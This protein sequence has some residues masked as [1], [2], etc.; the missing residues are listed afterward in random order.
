MDEVQ[1]KPAEAGCCD[2]EV[3]T[4]FT[5]DGSNLTIAHRTPHLS[6]SIAVKHESILDFLAKPYL[7]GQGVFST[8][9]NQ[10][11]LLTYFSIGSQLSSVTQWANKLT[12]FNLIRGKAKIRLIIN[13]NPFQQGKLLLSLA[14][15][16]THID[17]IDSSFAGKHLS[18]L[19]AIRQLPCVEHDLR[20]STTIL[21]VPYVTPYHWYDIKRAVYDWGT[22]FL[23]VMSPLL[24][25]AGGETT[26]D[27]SLFLSFEEVELAAPMITQMGKVKSKKGPP[28]EK[29]EDVY[30]G[31]GNVSKVLKAV[32][33]ASDA[34]ASVPV[35]API[36]GPVAWVTA[37]ASKAAA[38]FGWSKPRSEQPPGIMSKMYNRYMSTYDGEDT[39]VPLGLSA[40][41]K[42]GVSNETTLYDVDEMSFDFLKQVS[43]WVEDASW[44][45]SDVSGTSI[46]GKWISP[47]NIYEAGSKTIGAHT[48][49]Y[50][51]GPPIFYLANG[52]QY[53]R[54]SIELTIKLIKTDYHS[55]RLLITFTPYN[56]T[57]VTVPTTATSVL[58]L[59]EIVDI[60]TTDEIKL[61]LPYLL[62]ENFLNTYGGP[63]GSSVNMGYLNITVLNELRNPE[64]ASGTVKLQMY[65]S[66]GADFEFAG[67][68][69][70]LYEP[71]S[72]Q[73]DT[74]TL[75]KRTDKAIGDQERV[76]DSVYYSYES[77]GEKFLSVKQLLS[78]YC[79]LWTTSAS[80]S[81]DNILLWPWAAGINY[82]AA[83][84]GNQGSPTVGADAYNYLQHMYL[85]YRGGI[86]IGIQTSSTGSTQSF[87]NISVCN[88]VDN[89]A[90]GGALITNGTNVCTPG[91]VSNNNLD[92]TQYLRGFMA[93]TVTD[94]GN[95][96]VA[97]SV[98][99]YGCGR[100]S[101]V[102]TQTTSA[103]VPQ[104]RSTPCNKLLIQSTGDCGTF[105]LYRSC[106]DDFYFSYFIGCPPVM[107]SYT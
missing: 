33:G 29:E 80:G 11:D 9:N 76:P 89:A 7:V 92:T 90:Y 59:R 15:C 25:G 46:Y 49:N 73:M 42:I 13:S 47:L 30:S 69:R 41:N 55:G 28:T 103:T 18:T 12:G 62:A 48:T 65:Y 71:F 106:N 68:K 58:A 95:G 75:T 99:Y 57:A 31:G 64:T 85:F 4:T 19:A 70:F 77:M 14:P 17:A 98:P 97:A 63:T 56:N 20:D 37:A 93:P 5:D 6:S 8:T 45:N 91:T 82:M 72:T 24:T 83:G 61:N 66:G 27:Y 60:R 105:A 34:L 36:A 52:F 74:S 40:T 107:Y 2:S 84:T 10:R 78:R 102:L 54:G 1:N 3:T 100:A 16:Y 94:S 32:S 26:V 44:A 39:S 104:D 50:R 51:C 88:I 81:N 35:L 43:T 86:R 23:H 101:L 79:R 67:P 38:A 21:E 53:W 87:H 96:F 22:I